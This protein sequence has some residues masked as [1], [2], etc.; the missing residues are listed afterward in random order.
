MPPRSGPGSVIVVVPLPTRPLNSDEVLALAQLRRV[1][2]GYDTVLLAP[3]GGPVP[4]GEGPVMRIPR[5]F[6]GSAKAH[7]ALLVSR[8][9]YEAF[10]A[11]E[12]ILI[13]HLDAF[14]FS[15]QLAE[16]CAKGYSYIGPPWFEYT[17]VP[18]SPQG[19]GT[20]GFSLRRV[21]SCL[22]V[23]DSRVPWISARQYWREQRRVGVPLIRRGA[24]TVLKCAK[25]LNGVRWEVRH[26][27]RYGS[28]EDNF[29]AQ[30]ARHYHAGFVLP[31][32]Q[33]ALAFGW[34]KEPR[35]CHYLTQ[36]VLPFGCHGWSRPENRQFW[37][38]IL[39]EYAERSYPANQSQVR[40]SPSS[41]PT[42]A[43]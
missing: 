4:E 15:D 32:P 19:A 17:T 10:S 13:Y 25:P 6:F 29:W 35:L 42:F 38:P 30:R 1:L 18:P 3:P 7:G 24:F 27:N 20:G 37:L 5:R 22:A 14:V 11:Y 34:G 33:E 2:G 12:F 31:A 28:A 21:D 9:F 16:W 23:L 26:L 43:W 36:G 39:R 41:S 40:A 8:R